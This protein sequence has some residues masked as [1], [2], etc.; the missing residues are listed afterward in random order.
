MP[1]PARIH[2]RYLK[3][4]LEEVGM[5]KVWN[6]EYGRIKDQYEDT[7]DGR[8]AAFKNVFGCD[9]PV[10]P[11]NTLKSELL[12]NLFPNRKCAQDA[13][14][15]AT[16]GAKKVHPARSRRTLEQNTEQWQAT[17]AAE[18]E[19]TITAPVDENEVGA[20]MQSEEAALSSETPPSA[21]VS[22]G[23][24][25]S[26]DDIEWVSKHL[27][28]EVTRADAPSAQ[29]YGMWMTYHPANMQSFFWER[30]Y[31]KA[32]NLSEDGER[33]AKAD[34]RVN[35]NRLESLKEKVVAAIKLEM[36][37]IGV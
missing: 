15:K 20:N 13:I 24:V 12:V 2:R 19:F 18:Q 33:D 32:I 34:D 30:I 21:S 14:A 29:A 17:K 7:D 16:G 25:S 37:E 3:E 28:E 8:R 6:A 22:P 35:L 23:A 11:G 26:R 31:M 27:A 9:L 1:K 10:V 36:E 5:L 4:A